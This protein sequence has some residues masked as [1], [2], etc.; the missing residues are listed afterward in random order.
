MTIARII[1]AD[2]GPIC[3]DADGQAYGWVKVHPD[4]VTN[5]PSSWVKVPDH[6]DEFFVPVDSK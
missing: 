6:D 1:D 2:A 5:V 4:D 3:V